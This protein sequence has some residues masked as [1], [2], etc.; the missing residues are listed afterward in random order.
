MCPCIGVCVC[1][2]CVCVRVCGVCVCV[3]AC[4]RV[5]VWFWKLPSEEATAIKM[6][7][8]DQTQR[9]VCLNSGGG[10]NCIECDSALAS[11]GRAS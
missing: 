5:C 4:V 6:K 3:C 8:E 9:K 10:E 7:P 11:V 1:G 2:V